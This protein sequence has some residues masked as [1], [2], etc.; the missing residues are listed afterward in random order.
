MSAVRK[1]G[2]LRVVEGLLWLVVAVLFVWRITP[3]LR[4]AVGGPADGDGFDARRVTL[5]L[6][7]GTALPLD[8]LKGQVVLV[9]FWATWCPP[10]R[11]E[12]P[13]FQAEF[14][15]RRGQGFTVVGIS[16]DQGSRHAVAAFLQEHHITYPVAMTTRETDAAF[17]GINDLPT[18]F[19]LDRRGRVRYTVRGI[20]APEMLRAAVDRLLAEGR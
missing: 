13:G 18:S 4:A 10:C 3:Q 9:N 5:D 14:D 17:G 15:A 11:A 6:L 2:R 19:L 20:F 12:M 16:T 7:N 1:Q 8:A